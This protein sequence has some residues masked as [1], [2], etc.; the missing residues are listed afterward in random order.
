M[1]KVHVLSLVDDASPLADVYEVMLYIPEHALI[2]ID[3]EGG[4]IRF[5][6]AAVEL[7][8]A[9]QAV[10]E[11]AADP[12][13]RYELTANVSEATVNTLI[14]AGREYERASGAFRAAADQLTREV[15]DQ[16]RNRASNG[17]GSLAY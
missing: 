16:V 13:L 12:G 14:A 7:A 8:E 4:D 6:E 1:I 10:A 3:K 5:T 9:E 2:G 11:R 15:E 17:S